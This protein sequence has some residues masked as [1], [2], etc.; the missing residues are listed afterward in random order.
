M[1][2]KISLFVLIAGCIAGAIYWYNYTKEVHTPV[3]IAVNAIPNNAA[4][5]IE[6]KQIKK[7]YEKIS[8]TNLMW[9]EL[10]ST[11]LF[12][13]L[14]VQLN[15]IDSLIN[16][17]K[18]V[19]Q[20]LNNNTVYI[21]AHVS[22]AHSFDFLYTLSLPSIRDKSTIEDFFGSVNNNREPLQRNY[23]EVNISTLHSKNKDSLLF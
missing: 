12:S 7:V 13:K 19:E 15:Y 4:V 21:S 8:Q 1:I 14:N 3:S 11:E 5:I 23:D 16:K 17:N 10:K 22:G 6:C 9:E 2:K 18:A 20:L